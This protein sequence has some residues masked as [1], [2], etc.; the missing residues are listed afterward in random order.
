MRNIKF[1]VMLAAAAILTSCGAL[2]AIEEESIKEAKV[3]VKKALDKQEL[4]IEVNTILPSAGPSIHSVDGYYLKIKDGKAD[5]YLPFFGSSFSAPFGT[6]DMGIKFDACPV[7]IDKSE[8]KP[9][10]GKYVWRFEAVSNN[11]KV[12]VT[13]TFW[14]NG[15]ADIMC[16]RINSSIMNYSGNL[17]AYPEK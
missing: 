9:S 15:N 13:V 11:E 14:D 8:S 2:A 7:K 3:Y 16:H 10:K 17:I 12:N 4:A 5:S 1:I 6:D